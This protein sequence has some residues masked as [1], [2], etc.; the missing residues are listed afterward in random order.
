M[1]ISFDINVEPVMKHGQ[2][3][4]ETAYRMASKLKTKTKC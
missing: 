4:N 3:Q 1:E 2:N